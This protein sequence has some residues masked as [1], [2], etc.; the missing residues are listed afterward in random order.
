[1][2]ATEAKANTIKARYDKIQ[3][4]IS[5]A[6]DNGY[7]ECQVKNVYVELSRG[8]IDM[9]A[10]DGYNVEIVFSDYK[11]AYITIFWKSAEEGK[12]GTITERSLPTILP[13]RK[14][15][16]WFFSDLFSGGDGEDG[17]W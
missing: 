10:D 13:E 11:I 4:L 1:M 17:D 14:G 3:K 12:R 6:I 15:L 9:L 7:T 8:L 2:K 16:R 5:N